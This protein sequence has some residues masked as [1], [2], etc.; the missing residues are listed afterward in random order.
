[1]GPKIEAGIEFVECGG[2]ECIITS[3]ERVA[4]A[5]GGEAGTHIVPS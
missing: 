3:S 5:V 4:Q 1:M 2:R